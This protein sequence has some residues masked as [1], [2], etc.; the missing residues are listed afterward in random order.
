VHFAWFS[1]V[2]NGTHLAMTTVYD[3]DFDT[4]VEFFARDVPLFDDQFDYLAV[5]MPR[6]IQK[7]PKEFVEIIRRYNRAPLGNYF[8]SAY[9][10]TDTATIRNA[11]GGV[12]P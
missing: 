10:L 6:P 12:Q 2:E 4:Y 8:F 11:D 5:K 1:I 7:Y 9:P 3:G